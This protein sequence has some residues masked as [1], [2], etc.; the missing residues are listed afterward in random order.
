MRPLLCLAACQSVNEN[1]E[2]ALPAACAVEFIHAYSLIH[3]DLPALDN[4]DWRRGKPANHKQF[5]EA[6]AI[7]AGDGLQS[8]AFETLG[9]TRISAAQHVV[10]YQELSHATGPRGMCGGQV[11]DMAHVQRKESQILQVYAMKTG[12]IIRA[13][14]RMGAIVG[15]ANDAQLKALTCFAENLGQAFQIVD[16]VLDLTESFD[17]LGKTP[18]KDAAQ[19]KSTYPARVGVEASEQR[20]NTLYT[21]ALHHLEVTPLSCKLLLRHLAEQLVVRKT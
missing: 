14:I 9:H 11:L 20:V 12:A 19:N 16:D 10:L 18:G 6:M 7:L 3:D 4:D 8:L 2:A 17:T 5:G 21:D 1:W 15:G 13:A